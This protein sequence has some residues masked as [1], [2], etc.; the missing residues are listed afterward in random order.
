MDDKDGWGNNT[1]HDFATAVNRAFNWAEKQGLIDRNPVAPGRE[2]GPGSRAS[3]RSAPRISPRSWQVTGAEFPTCWIRLGDGVRPQEIRQDRGQARDGRPN[4]IVFPPKEAKGKKCHRVVYLNQAGIR[5]AEAARRGST[6]PVPLFRNS[7]GA[8]WNKD[9]INCAFCRLRVRLAERLMERE[10]KP[11]PVVSKVPRKQLSQ[12][13]RAAFGVG[14]MERGT[15]PLR[16][17]ARAPVPHGCLAEGLRDGGDQG[18]GVNLSTLSSLMGHQDGRMLTTVYFEGLSG[19]RAHGRRRREGQ[20][21]AWVIPAQ[22]RLPCAAQNVLERPHRGGRLLFPDAERATGNVFTA[23]GLLG[24]P[25][26]G[27]G[28]AR[29]GRIGASP[30]RQGL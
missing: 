4:R 20:E 16:E 26:P 1:K 22:D 15:R 13:C 21:A 5:D 12:R 11:R 6:R 27:H 2:A 29:R 3:W 8:P 9:S 17:R 25:D 23:D 7:E 30:R 10:G 19:P 28:R 14:Q 18:E 24:D